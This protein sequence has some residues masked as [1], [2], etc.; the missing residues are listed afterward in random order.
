MNVNRLLSPIAARLRGIAARGNLTACTDPGTG[1]VMRAQLT[2][3]DGGVNSNVPYPGHYGHASLPPAGCKPFVLANGGDSG[4]SVVVAMGDVT[5]RIALDDGEVAIYDDL[6]QSVHL[7]R[8]GIVM[9]GAGLPVTITDTPLV[10]IE[11]ELTVTGTI[12]DLCDSGGR[13]MDGMRDIYDRHRHQETNTITETP[14]E[15][16]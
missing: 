15:T 14:T 8:A 1:D 13:S 7:T 10:R 3:D 6:G 12:T 9:R 2:T 5:W 4:Q 16:M 11:A